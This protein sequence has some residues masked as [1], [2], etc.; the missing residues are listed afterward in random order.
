MQGAP[1]AV[2]DKL[3]NA[4][5]MELK[6]YSA[7]GGTILFGTDVGFYTEY[8]PTRE[9]EDMKT[10]LS[11]NEIL[12]SLTTNPS[13]FFKATA[14]GRVEKGMDADLVVLD[15]DPAA[16]VRNFAKVAYT[17]RAGKVIY[18]S[19]QKQELTILPSSALLR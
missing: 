13:E 15:G 17:I 16:D 11:W 2:V 10:V 18:N 6:Q 5:E 3:V 7:V 12:A 4:G 9:L 14:K 1:Q 8:D 19:T